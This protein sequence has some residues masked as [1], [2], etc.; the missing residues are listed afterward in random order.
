MVL[1]Q[2]GQDAT[3]VVGAAFFSV[4]MFWAASIVYTYSLPP[5]RVPGARLGRAEHREPDSGGR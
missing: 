3:T 5:S 1:K 4:S 2:C